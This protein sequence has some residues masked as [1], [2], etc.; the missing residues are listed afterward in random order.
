MNVRRHPIPPSVYGLAGLAIIGAY[1]VAWLS[2]LL[3]QPQPY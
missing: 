2:W 3:F 1:A